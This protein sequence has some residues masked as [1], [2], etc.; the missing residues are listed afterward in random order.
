[1]QLTFTEWV[2]SLNIYDNNQGKPTN[3]VKNVILYLCLTFFSQVT[4]CYVFYL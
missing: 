2:E 4:I 1:M 3:P